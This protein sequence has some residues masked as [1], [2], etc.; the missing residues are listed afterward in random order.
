MRWPWNL[1]EFG[2]EEN[3]VEEDTFWELTKAD[4]RELA[5]EMAEGLDDAIHGAFEK[6]PNVI[7]EWK[8]FRALLDSEI[9]AEDA[10]DKVSEAAAVAKAKAAETEKK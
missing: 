1:R 7:A 10:F 9:S 4:N 5:K 8:K 6:T 3:T 2:R